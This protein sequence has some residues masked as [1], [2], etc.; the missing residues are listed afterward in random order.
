[1]TEPIAASTQ[2]WTI[3]K[4]EWGNGPWQHETDGCSWM[5]EAGLLGA[6]IRHPSFGNLNGYVAVPE[7]H[8]LYGKAYDALDVMVH[9][10]LTF[11]GQATNSA[12]FR[13]ALG[14]VGPGW[15]WFGF[16]CAHGFDYCPAMAVRERR[17]GIPLIDDETS[18]KDEP[19]VRREVESLAAQ[20]AALR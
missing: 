6:I 16:D 9:G 7:S 13:Q 4:S 12:Y 17:I 20:L 1:M 10:G 8:P 11:G 18:Y 19:Y 14:D 2:E 15:H 3:D 5:T